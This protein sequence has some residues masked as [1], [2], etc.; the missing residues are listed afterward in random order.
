MI[1][2][3]P[4]STDITEALSQINLAISY[5]IGWI[6]LPTVGLDETGA[7]ELAEAVIPVCRDNDVILTLENQVEVVNQL[8]NHGVLL[9]AGSMHPAFVRER[10][11]PH[12]IVGIAADSNYDFNTIKGVDIDYIVL[13]KN[14]GL[15]D[16]E[17]IVNRLS[18]IAIDLPVVISG[19][20]MPDDILST[21][22]K[23]IL[24]EKL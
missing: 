6:Q 23:G 9:T 8:H 1:I 17:D 10:L 18:E 24:K 21:G 5:G 2:F 19:E 13:D 7:R 22:V 16:A 12:A 3:R 20:Y 14:I 11:G 15:H 4:S